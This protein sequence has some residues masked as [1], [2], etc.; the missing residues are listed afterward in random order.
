MSDSTARNRPL[1]PAGIEVRERLESDDARIVDVRN[2]CAPFLPDTTVE[3]LHRRTNPPGKPGTINEWFVAVRGEDLLGLY[4]LVEEWAISEPGTYSAWV[5]VLPD[6]RQQGI[7]TALLEHLLQRAE[8]HGA[9]RL[10]GSVYE[11]VTGAR[12]FAEHR[13]FMPTGTVE[14]MSILD[15]RS[16]QLHGYPETLSR[17]ESEG[18]SFRSLAES[19]LDDEAFLRAVADLDYQTALDIPNQESWDQ[20]PFE[21][22]RRGILETEDIGPQRFWVALDDGRPVG[23]AALG[24]RG[25]NGL[26]NAY[27]GVHREYRGRGVARALKLKTIEYAQASGFEFIMTGNNSDNRRMLDVNIRLGYRMLPAQIE[28]GR[29]LAHDSG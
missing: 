21:L 3:D 4:S 6:H 28:V 10:L 23:L 27:T 26:T 20:G 22:W 25:A 11:G 14:R 7:G 9:R 16:A 17:L 2:R 8:G 12:E 1:G 29:R 15:V 13:G 5:G 18:L 19:G 24:L